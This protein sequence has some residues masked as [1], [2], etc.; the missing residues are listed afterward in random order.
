MGAST[1]GPAHFT[2]FLSFLLFSILVLFRAS[3]F[4]GRA[5]FRHVKHAQD[6]NSRYFSARP[7]IGPIV[8]AYHAGGV[9]PR[10]LH[11]GLNPLAILGAHAQRA[12]R[13]HA[14]FT[15]CLRCK[16]L[17]TARGDPT[18]TQFGLKAR[19]SPRLKIAARD[20]ILITAK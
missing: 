7:S 9:F 17:L 15:V 13:R 12:T 19:H 1:Q 16:V 10:F 14:E 2:L 6:V 4:L 18:S 3:N 8:L 20:S 11:G 5:Y